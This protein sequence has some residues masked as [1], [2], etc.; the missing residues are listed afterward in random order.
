L[1]IIALLCAQLPK[2]H[3]FRRAFE[4]HERQLILIQ[5]NSA[6]DGILYILFL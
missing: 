3:V 6:R 5:A 1:E 2:R 4:Q